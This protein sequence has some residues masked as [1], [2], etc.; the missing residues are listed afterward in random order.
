MDTGLSINVYLNNDT[1]LEIDNAIM[2]DS[3]DEAISYI[4][5]NGSH[6]STAIFTSSGDNAS[7][8]IREVHSKM[9]TVNT[10]PTIE[11]IC[12]VKQNDLVNEKTIVYPLSF[13]FENRQ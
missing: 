5:Y 7:K 4:N 6:Y 8:F 1:K 13:V 10:S 2:V 3:L 12:D 9:V 11:R